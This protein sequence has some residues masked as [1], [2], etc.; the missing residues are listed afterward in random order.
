MSTLMDYAYLRAVGDGYIT[1]NHPI[2]NHGVLAMDREVAE[3]TTNTLRGLFRFL[4]TTFSF[5]VE[6]IDKQRVNRMQVM[7]GCCGASNHL[8]GLV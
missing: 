7:R 5:L 6:W 3:A 1:R 4:R 2:V 8:K